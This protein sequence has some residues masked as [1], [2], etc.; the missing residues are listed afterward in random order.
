LIVIL[1][2]GLC[3]EGLPQHRGDLNHRVLAFSLAAS[4]ILMPKCK[5]FTPI[6]GS[7]SA[8]LPCRGKAQPG[9]AFCKKHSDAIFGAM[10]GAFQYSQPIDT[11]EHFCDD[12]HPCAFAIA[13]RRK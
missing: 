6:A 13:Q 1:S 7:R 9:S 10:L 5:A 11:I 2:R 8:W 4:P 12:E 3:G